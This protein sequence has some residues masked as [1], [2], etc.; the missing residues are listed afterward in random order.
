MFAE[1][2]DLDRAEVTGALHSGWGIAVAALDYAPVG[3]G[4][5][6]YRARDTGGAE[7]FLSVDLEPDVPALER[8]FGTAAALREAG[9]EFVASPVRRPDGRCVTVTAGGAAVSVAAV[10][11]GRSHR[12]GDVLP[13][14]VRADLLD[15]LGRLHSVPVPPGAPVDPLTVPYRDELDGPWGDGPYA[16]PARELLAARRRVV[17]D[18]FVRYDA[19][20][21]VVTAARDT[22]V[23]THGEPHPGNVMLPAGGGLRLIDWDTVAV[24]PRARDLWMVA[25]D[26]SPATAL[27]RLRWTLTDICAFV[28]DLRAPH[29]DD[30]DTRLA[31]RELSGYLTPAI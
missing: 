2:P 20:V 28:R 26:D 31:W 21:P 16:R 30:A 13:A 7:W 23:V 27:Y 4:A 14:P 22:W 17:A 5:H 11:D 19:L 12:F 24:A 8:A 15:A 10:I 1:P 25:P 29:A 3:Y 18:L 6:H 9:L